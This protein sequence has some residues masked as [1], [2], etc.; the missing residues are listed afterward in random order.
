[1]KIANCREANLHFAIFIFQ[2]AILLFQFAIPL[3]KFFASIASDLQL[4]SG[5]RHLISDLTSGLCSSHF[6]SVRERFVH[7]DL[8]RVFQIRAH[9]NS[10][11]DSCHSDFQRL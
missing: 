4:I 1:M 9:R 6:V 10:H 8:V 7:G 5:L 3:S 11:R 2:F